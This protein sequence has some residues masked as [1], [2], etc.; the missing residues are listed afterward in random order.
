MMNFRKRKLSRAKKSWI[1]RAV[2]AL[3]ACVAALSAVSVFNSA[4]VSFGAPG[5]DQM[6]P[7]KA[8]AI[9]ARWRKNKSDALARRYADA[10][11]AAGLDDRLVR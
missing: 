1:K 4:T 6:T 3:V 9:G 8:R 5:R 2:M 10:L 7:A 11:A